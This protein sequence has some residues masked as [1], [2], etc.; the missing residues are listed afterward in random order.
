MPIPATELSDYQTIVKHFERGCNFSVT[1]ESVFAVMAPSICTMRNLAKSTADIIRDSK[2][3]PLDLSKETEDSLKERLKNKLEDCIPCDLRADFKETLDFKAQWR[4]LIKYYMDYFKNALEQIKA[5]ADLLSGKGEDKLDL[6]SF[7][8]FFKDF[9]CIPDLQRLIAALTALAMQLGLELSSLFDLI[10]Q[11]IGPI[12]MPFL[13]Q[14]INQVNQFFQMA[15]KPLECIINAITTQLS[16]LDYG[17]LFSNPTNA[18]VRGTLESG[19]VVINNAKIDF[20]PL[21]T[22]QNVKEHTV[23]LEAEQNVYNVRQRASTIDRTNPEA[24]AQQRRQEQEAQQAYQTALR[25]KDLTAIGKANADLT[26]TLNTVRSALFSLIKYVQ[27]VVDWFNSFQEK[28]IGDFVKML[29]TLTGGGTGMIITLQNK[30]AIVQLIKLLKTL[31]DLYKKGKLEC[32]SN[33]LAPALS[34]NSDALIYQDVNGNVIVED[35]NND[36]ESAMNN[37]IQGAGQ[38][39]NSDISIQDKLKSI[40]KFTGNPIIDSSLIQAAETI[41]T[42]RKITISCSKTSTENTSKVNQWISELNQL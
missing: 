2:L 36:I 41:T 6:C 14:I 3:Q 37:A 38:V 1:E 32:N 18:Q 22:Q 25:D 39:A 5:M 9:V 4:Q 16:K 30:L 15:I 34:R 35:K 26:K 7:L 42:K 40:I 11:L 21:V 33:N 28:V 8:D 29:G 23:A 27:M 31:K 13:N 24:V 19:P 20:N 17:A 10:L 12:M